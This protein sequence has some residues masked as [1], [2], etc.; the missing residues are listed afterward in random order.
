M[1]QSVGI[2]LAEQQ[3]QNYAYRMVRVLV[4]ISQSATHPTSYNL[5]HP[6]SQDLFIYKPSQLPVEH[7]TRLPFSA[8]RT[9]HTRRPLSHQLPTYTPGSRECT[10]G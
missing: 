5:I 2:L 7:A 1:H 4:S 6:W 3:F 8:R 10:C 9:D